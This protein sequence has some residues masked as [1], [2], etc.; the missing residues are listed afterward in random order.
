MTVFI[1]KGSE[2]HV[3]EIN[4]FIANFL[5]NIPNFTFENLYLE[6]AFSNMQLIGLS[7]KATKFH[8]IGSWML[9][10]GLYN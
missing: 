10:P 7:S 9:V 4:I 2:D 5:P 6:I 8:V 1:P 3:F